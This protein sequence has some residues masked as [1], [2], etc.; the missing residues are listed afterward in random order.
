LIPAETSRF[1]RFLRA[2]WT[3]ITVYVLAGLAIVGLV[4]DRALDEPI[5]RAVEGRLNT[6]LVGY[7]ARVPHLDFHL[8]GLAMDLENVRVSQNAHP[9]PPVLE[10]PRLSMSVQWLSL[11]RAKLVADAV[12]ESPKLHVDLVQLAEEN[13]DD[14]PFEDRGWQDT[15][16][17]IYP[18]KVNELV[19]RNASLFYLDAPESRPL[20]ATQVEVHAGNIRNIRSRDREYPSTIHVSGRVFDEG[21][22]VLDGNADFLA[23][24]RPGVK[25][26]MVISRIDL[27]YF[28]PIL[29]RYDLE[30]R[31]G[32][33]G[34]SGRVE[35]ARSVEF[36]EL[37]SVLLSDAD[38]DYVMGAAPSP[39]ARRLGRQITAV[40]RQAMND[41]ET[42]FRIR[43]L[44]LEHGTIGLVNKTA[45]PPY[46]VY[47]A[48]ANLEID[49]LSSRAED[50]PAYVALAG[51]FMGTGRLHGEAE[52]LPEG[53][54]PNFAL[55]LEVED[56]QLKP[57]N[58][59]FQAHGNFDVAA[60]V[61]SAYLEMRVKDGHVEG[62]VKPLFR[63]IDVYDSKQD[64]GESA[65]HKMYEKLV[66]G[67]VKLLTNPKHH[68]VATVARFSG[69]A[70][71]PHSS[72]VEIVLGL[73]RN[74]FLEA[75]LPG[76]ENE[77]ARIDPL[78]YRAAKKEAKNKKES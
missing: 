59:L 37:D 46:R 70:G 62:Y 5:R 24:P 4:L 74:A 38:V 56:T 66:G 12:F 50:G 48:G 10:V 44:S 25:A 45:S 40:A 30:V 77:V 78:R 49:N 63:D 68:E 67:V 22:A 73:L 75:I 57:M 35:Y 43:R 2:R 11:L 13:R 64:K 31:H 9:D 20:Q 36:V 29:R 19:V 15:L 33:L 6:T 76:F 1:P 28:Q 14:V 8:L 65:L 7:T 61:F 71:A 47:A 69:P 21:R 41:P 39:E 34:A 55:K 58:A 32:F 23:K 53:K 42:L 72:T 27:G 52:F 3:R 17:A 60:G 26:E 51:T 16:Q 54:E 18:L